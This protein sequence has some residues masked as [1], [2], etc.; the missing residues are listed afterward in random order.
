MNDFAIHD[1]V[2]G[3]FERQVYQGQL[4]AIIRLTFARIEALLREKCDSQIVR[5]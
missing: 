1:R 2:Q 3:F 5:R 4:L